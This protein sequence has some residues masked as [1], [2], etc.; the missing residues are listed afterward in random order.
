MEAIMIT[1]NNGYKLNQRKRKRKG[2]V[3]VDC[4]NWS[5]EFEKYKSDGKENEIHLRNQV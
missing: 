4:S 1:N 3:I 5:V 2:Q